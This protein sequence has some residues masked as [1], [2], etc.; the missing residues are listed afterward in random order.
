L[1]RRIRNEKWKEEKKELEWISRRKGGVRE[2]RR[3][4]EE[5]ENDWKEQVIF[6]KR[7]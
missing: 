3:G 7:N 6:C 5:K 4:V 2:R 1:S